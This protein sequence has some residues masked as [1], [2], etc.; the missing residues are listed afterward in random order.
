MSMDYLLFVLRIYSD[1]NSHHSL[2]FMI[3]TKEMA[4]LTTEPD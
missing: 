2:A 3:S 1:I 4:L